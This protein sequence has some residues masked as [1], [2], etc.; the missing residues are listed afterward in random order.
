[1][2]KTM[3]WIWRL[4]HFIIL[5][6]IIIRLI[7]VIL[8]YHLIIRLLLTL[9]LY[10]NILPMSTL[11]YGPITFKIALVTS[12]QLLLFIAIAQGLVIFEHHLDINP[13]ID[14]NGAIWE[15][16]IIYFRVFSISILGLYRKVNLFIRVW[17]GTFLG[18]FAANEINWEGIIFHW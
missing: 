17:R 5:K 10:L 11:T 6:V 4:I 3:W 7:L 2:N 16:C 15:S 18:I 13:S 14:C 1:M 12:F 9:I 8:I